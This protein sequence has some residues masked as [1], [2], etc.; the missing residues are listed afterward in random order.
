MKIQE[1]DVYHGPALMQIVEHDSF[2]ALNKADEKYGHYLV[3]NDRRL[4]FKYS[5]AESGPW[6]FTFQ[7]QDLA[8]LKKDLGTRGQT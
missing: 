6:S 8:A 3:N 1:Q 4:C 5:T 2:K 7:S